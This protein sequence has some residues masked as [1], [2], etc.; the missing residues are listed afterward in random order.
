MGNFKKM[1]QFTLDKATRKNYVFTQQLANV[2]ALTLSKCVEGVDKVE[3][4][5]SNLLQCKSILIELNGELD[6]LIHSLIISNKDD[7][8]SAKD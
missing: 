3:L 1:S 4:F 6:D 7:G 8:T 5:S 2:L